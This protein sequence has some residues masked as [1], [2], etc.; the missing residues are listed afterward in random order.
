MSGAPRAG[1]RLAHNAC[2]FERA[3]AMRSKRGG[4][5][6]LIHAL[7]PV[8]H[9][10]ISLLFIACGVA[11]IAFA[12]M[13]LWSAVTAEASVEGRIDEVLESLALVTVALAALELG[14]TIIEEQVE[15]E[16]H[17]SAPTRARRFLSRFLVVLVVALS[18]EAL[19]LVFKYSHEAPENIPYAAVVAFAAG[20]LIASWGLFVRLNRAA[21]ELEPEAMREA[22]EED[23]ELER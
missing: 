10:V 21:E 18:I 19:V 15:R 11:L 22:K 9:F 6:R 20:A 17:M 1:T 12:C 7:F 3:N 23:R 4:S 5:M 8:G 13:Q 16:A 14:E 2:F